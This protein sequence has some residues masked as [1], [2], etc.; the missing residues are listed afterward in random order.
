MHTLPSQLQPPLHRLPQ[1]P[2]IHLRPPPTK[3]SAAL[4][5]IVTKDFSIAQDLIPS[6]SSR[7]TSNGALDRSDESAFHR[8]ALNVRQASMGV[9]D[10]IHLYTS[11]LHD[12][13]M[14]EET[15][16][17]RDNDDA[18]HLVPTA[19]LDQIETFSHKASMTTD[20]GLQLRLL[21]DR[22]VRAIKASRAL[23]HAT[24]MQNSL[25][26]NTNGG[27]GQTALL[28]AL[29]NT[30]S[31]LERSAERCRYFLSRT[32]EPAKKASFLTRQGFKKTVETR[33][34]SAGAFAR[35]AD[36]ILREFHAL[37]AIREKARAVVRDWQ[38]AGTTKDDFLFRGENEERM[39]NAMQPA[40]GE[41]VLK[42]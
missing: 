6:L 41:W 25:G 28:N 42:D 9:V 12:F 40:A 13:T 19:L 21:F 20:S 38:F 22:L 31:H 5:H 3:E 8:T 32:Q 18:T 39:W 16:D 15:F 11:C 27:V 35:K 37:D 4:W 33:L 23:V 30:L 17:D 34:G 29:L 1:T 24:R 26:G 10:G 36:V 14:R 2:R 7:V